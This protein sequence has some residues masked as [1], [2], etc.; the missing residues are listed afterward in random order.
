MLPNMNEIDIAHP[1]I[2]NLAKVNE[3]AFI[4]VI[5][6]RL[7]ILIDEAKKK[8]LASGGRRKKTLHK[9]KKL[10][11]VKKKSIKKKLTKKA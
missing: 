11:Y 9:R 7:K 4:N 10:P 5:Y 2:A 8:K 6:E 3:P 1:F